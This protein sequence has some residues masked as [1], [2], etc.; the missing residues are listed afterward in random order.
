MK[1]TVSAALE[2]DSKV[3]ATHGGEGAKEREDRLGIR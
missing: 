3:D 2:S 1:G